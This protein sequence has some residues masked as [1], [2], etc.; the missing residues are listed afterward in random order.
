MGLDVA[1]SPG[2][3]KGLGEMS[4][5]SGLRAMPLCIS[6]LVVTTGGPEHVALGKM[7]VVVE[8]GKGSDSPGVIIG[9]VRAAGWT[10]ELLVREG[11]GAMLV[12][13]GVGSSRGR[14]LLCHMTI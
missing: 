6:I 10:M 1:T 5:T 8:A 9:M 4:T 14:G 2:T 13:G 3:S 12:A 7:F 11:L